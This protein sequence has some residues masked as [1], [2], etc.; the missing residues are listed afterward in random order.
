[1]RKNGDS[2][3]VYLAKWAIGIVGVLIT[4]ALGAGAKSS[5]QTQKD[6]RG[7]QDQ[8]RFNSIQIQTV[9][10]KVEAL[11]IPPRWL[12]EK[13]DRIDENLEEHMRQTGSRAHRGGGTS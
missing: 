12:E 11:E 9:D 10:E 3:G 7:L 6:M 5:I 2:W 8:M 13:V 4:M 1:M